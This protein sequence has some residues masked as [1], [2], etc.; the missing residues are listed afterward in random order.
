MH[1]LCSLRPPSRANAHLR[2][3]QCNTLATSRQKQHTSSPAIG[4]PFRPETR[5]GCP[6]AT[7]SVR[8]PLGVRIERTLPQCVPATTHCPMRSMPLLTIRVAKAPCPLSS[9]ASTTVP[10]NRTLCEALTLSS[11]AC[12]AGFKHATFQGRRGSARH[13]FQ[14]PSMLRT[15]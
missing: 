12:V 6:G 7:A 13:T 4:T 10:S 3:K 14:S 1:A 8:E 11:S 5:A 9:F 2:N 15:W